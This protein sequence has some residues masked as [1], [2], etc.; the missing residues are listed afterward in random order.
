[1][2]LFL[3]LDCST[4]SLSALV[5]CSDTG[6]ISYVTS[7]NFEENFPE[8]ETTSGFIKGEDGSCSTS[9][10][11]WLDA[12]DLLLEQLKAKGAPLDQIAAIGGAAQ[13]HA[14]VYLNSA[15]QEK[16]GD[17]DIGQSLADQL[18]GTLSHRLSPIWMDNTTSAYCE[19]IS[20][21]LD[22]FGKDY[23]IWAT[24]SKVTERFAGPQI[25]KFAHTNPDLYKNTSRI[26]LCSSFMASVLT[27]TDAP[28]DYSDASGMNLLNIHDYKWDAPCMEATAR[29]LDQKLPE[30]CSSTTILGDI[31]P[32]FAEKYGFSADTQV[33]A[34]MG[35]NPASLVGMNAA[36][37]GTRVLSLG[38]SYT[39]FAAMDEVSYDP[40]SYGHVFC[41]PLGGYMALCCYSNGALVNE[42]LRKRFSLT[43]EEF[44]EVVL[45]ALNSS[46]RIPNFNKPFLVD[47]ITPTQPANPEMEKLEKFKFDVIPAIL[48]SAFIN[49]RHSSSW[50]TSLSDC[51]FVTGGGSQSSSVRKLVSRI[52]DCEVCSIA[53][54]SSVATGAAKV[55]QIAYNSSLTIK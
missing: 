13:Q 35:D 36:E 46:S 20:S 28:V 39:L 26:H 49:I 14:T 7:V 25:R 10:C 43:W 1:M 16:V 8:Y 5:Y 12:L 30:L 2:P 41:N 55:A 18:V 9:P 54:P 48:Q 38:T 24:G 45:D 19:E 51:I 52:F 6:E 23:V 50:I 33:T 40:N 31:A 17:L 11:M 21:N 42:H 37:V 3:G 32:Y 53:V 44:D 29:D 4:Q 27:G 22:V 47:E 15:F 34:W